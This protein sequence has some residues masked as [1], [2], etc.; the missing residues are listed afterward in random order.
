MIKIVDPKTAHKIDMFVS[1]LFKLRI[2]YNQYKV[3]TYKLISLTTAKTLIL[4]LSE[5][6][7]K[8]HEFHGKPSQHPKV[9]DESKVT[10]SVLELQE[11]HL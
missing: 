8:K 5:P 6:F 11:A 9:Q 10:S 2:L 4:I 1:F 3:W 7:W